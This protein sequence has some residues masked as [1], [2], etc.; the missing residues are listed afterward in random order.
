MVALLCLLARS[1]TVEHLSRQQ[2]S[3]IKCSVSG[4]DTILCL[5]SDHGKSS[6][7]AA[8]AANALCNASLEQVCTSL[9]YAQQRF[10]AKRAE[11]FLSRLSVKKKKR[12]CS[13]GVKLQRREKL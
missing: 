7:S 9:M 2:L 6:I 12:L 4:L 11:P 8:H 10:D 3:A 1:E 13:Q 5:Q